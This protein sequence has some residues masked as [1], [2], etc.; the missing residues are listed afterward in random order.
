M[1]YFKTHYYGGVRKYQ[2]VTIPQLRGV[3]VK[4]GSWWMCASAR[5]EPKLVITDLL[6]HLG[7]EQSKTP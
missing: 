7:G 2:W 5:D 6:P 4:D 3:V 1:A